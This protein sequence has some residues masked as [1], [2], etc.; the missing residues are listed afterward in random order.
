MSGL[1]QLNALL[2]PLVRRS[3]AGDRHAFND[4]V[5]QCHARVYRWA[6]AQTG[7]PDEADDVAQDVLVRLHAD[8][9]R[10]RF[11]SR[12]TT[13]LYQ[14][15]R[16][17]VIDHQRRHRRRTKLAERAAHE[18]NR[19]V[20]EPPDPVDAMQSADTVDAIMALFRDLPRMQR[21]VFDL[22]DLQG[23]TPLE[24]SVLL[25]MNPNTVRAHLFRAR[26]AIR[27]RMLERHPELV[28]DHRE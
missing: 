2:E 21:E 11:Q 6:L 20:V 18:G 1:E 13:W 4:L 24:V 27:G 22:V 16:N 17:L 8:L 15:T 3:Q 14:V 7:H 12:F 5:G 23:M 28:E 10:Y 19:T 9:G 26:Q 25:V